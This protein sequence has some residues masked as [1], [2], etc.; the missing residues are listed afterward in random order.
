[1]VL[2]GGTIE[3]TIS[4]KQRMNSNSIFKKLLTRTFSIY[5]KKITVGIR[6]AVKPTLYDCTLI[7]VMVTPFFI[8]LYEIYLQNSHNNF[9][10]M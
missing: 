3:E 2:R 8:S 7:T 5:Q 1:M 4:N 6:C 9:T 10:V